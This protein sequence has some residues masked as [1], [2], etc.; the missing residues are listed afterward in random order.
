MEAALVPQT[1][2][3]CLSKEAIFNTLGRDIITVF[4]KIL[5]RSVDKMQCE[6]LYCIACNK[7][8]P[9]SR[10]WRKN[11]ASLCSKNVEHSVC[12]ACVSSAPFVALCFHVLSLFTQGPVGTWWPRNSNSVNWLQS[13]FS[14]VLVISVYSLLHYS[15]GAS[16]THCHCVCEWTNGITDI[17]TESPIMR[18]GPHKVKHLF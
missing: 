12:R 1:F 3:L 10:I 18:I 5:T 11:K 9:I 13:N 2:I 6:T 7:P 16:V 8:N 14:W 4:L 15:P 17:S